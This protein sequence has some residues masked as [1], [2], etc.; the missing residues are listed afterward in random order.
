MNQLFPKKNHIQ[1]SYQL[2]NKII[3]ALYNLIFQ[4]IQLQKLCDN[5][6]DSLQTK[7]QYG[8]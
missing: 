8:W 6:K 7:N 2:H 5:W 4:P 3:Y 1:L